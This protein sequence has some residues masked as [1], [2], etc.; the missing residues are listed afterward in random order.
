MLQAVAQEEDDIA[1]THALKASLVDMDG[2]RSVAFRAVEEF[3]ED[4]GEHERALNELKTESANLE[5][6]FKKV[7]P[8]LVRVP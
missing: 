4:V 6:A 3:S 7:G 8:F 5:K 1:A 2:R